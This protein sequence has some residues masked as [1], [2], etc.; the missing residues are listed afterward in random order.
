MIRQSFYANVAHEQYINGTKPFEQGN[1]LWADGQ[2]FEVSDYLEFVKDFQ[3]THIGLSPKSPLY[4]RTF[5][6]LYRNARLAS[7][8]TNFGD[9]FGSNTELFAIRGWSPYN[10]IKLY[11]YDFLLRKLKEIHEIP[12]DEHKLDKIENI[13]LVRISTMDLAYALMIDWCAHKEIFIINFTR[14]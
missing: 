12:I 13:Q 5:S 4:C 7:F 8:D 10:S 14:T 2:I 6:K 1:H 3:E 11:E 9:S